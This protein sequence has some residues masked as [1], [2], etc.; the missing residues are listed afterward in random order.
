[1]LRAFSFI[2][3]FI[4]ANSAASVYNS[5]TSQ[6][7]QTVSPSILSSISHTSSMTRT[8]SP[9]ISSVY[10]GNNNYTSPDYSVVNST[11]SVTGVSLISA[12]VFLGLLLIIYYIYINKPKHSST[13]QQSIITM[14]P[15]PISQSV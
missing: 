13:R 8:S 3:L 15:H 14:M 9:S 2:S 4:F 7:S 1:M 11:L 12:S 6:T 10:V 5:Q